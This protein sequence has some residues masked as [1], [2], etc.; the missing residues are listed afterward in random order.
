MK[1]GFFGFDLPEGKVKYNDAL[2]EALTEKFQPKK[3][4]PYFAEFLR[5]EYVQVDGI[6]GARANALDVLIL[7]MERIEGRLERV[8]DEAEK[9]LLRRCQAHLEEEA[10]LC[11]LALSEP[12]Q[13]MV[14]EAGPITLQP[15][16]FA[17]EADDLDAVIATMLERAGLLFFYTGGKKEVHAWLVRQGSDIVTCAGKIHSDLA[18]GFIRAEVVSVPEFLGVHN[19]HEAK[20]KGLVRI[21]ERDYVIREGDMI[22]VRF[23]V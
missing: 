13:E 15:T 8:S 22:D 23:S 2:V 16:V 19:M 17:N 11:D 4:S 3:V 21:V 14:R 20:E 12:E 9:E 6:F 5:E 10:P 1:I 7:D 18:R